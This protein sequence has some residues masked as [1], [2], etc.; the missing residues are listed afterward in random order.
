MQAEGSKRT[1]VGLALAVAFI[2]SGQGFAKFNKTLNQY[3]GI[4]ALSKQRYYEVIKRM[5]PHIT[6]ILQVLPEGE[7]G[8][9]K[10]AV[11]T[12]DGVWHTRGHQ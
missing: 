10:K 7:L 12:S 6:G 4:S 9:W 2:I 1:V 11:V 3:L 5:Y 8:H